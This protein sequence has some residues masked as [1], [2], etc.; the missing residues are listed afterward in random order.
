M[1]AESQLH[2]HYHGN[3]NAGNTPETLTAAVI[4]SLPYVGFPAAIKALRIIRE[5]YTEPAVAETPLVRLSKITVDPGSMDEYNTLLKEEIE[6]SMRLEPGVLALYATAEKDAPHK[7]TILE[8]YA[9]PAAYRS[10]L[11]T[12]HFRKYKQATL[13]MVKELELVDVKPL[14]TGMKIK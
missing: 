11:Q 6:T 7:L 2:S 4:Q 12:P 3:I 10:H 14:I 13:Q 9:G 5:E 1:G 8:I